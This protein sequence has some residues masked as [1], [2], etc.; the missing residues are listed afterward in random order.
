M[1]SRPPERSGSESA[2]G[3]HLVRSLGLTQATALVAGTIIGASIF[4]QAS[5]VTT[6]VPR[7]PVILFAWAVSGV[8]SLFGALV[9]AE[10]ASAFPRSGGIYVYLREEFG[11]LPRFLWGWSMFWIMHSGIIAVM[12]VVFARYVGYFAPLD[13]RGVRLVAVAAIPVISAI[14]YF[15]VKLGSTVQTLFTA[16]KIIAIMLLVS[17][18]FVVG[19]HL[20]AH[21]AYGASGAA[22]ARTPAPITTTGFLLSLIAGLF[23]FGGWHL[24]TYTAEETVRPERTIPLALMIGIAIV[25]VCYVA[26]NTLYF[27]VLPLDRVAASTRVAADA[28]VVLVGASAGGVIS[29]LVIFSTFG[30]MSGS[31]LGAPRVY[32]AMARDGL[33]F[34]W[35]S[36]VHPRYRTPHRAIMLQAVWASALVWTGT[37]RQLFTRVISIQWAF[38]AVLALGVFVLRR[39][40]DYRPAY[41]TWGYPVV[42]A[43]FVAASLAIVFTRFRSEPFDSLLGLAL[44]GLG[45]PVYYAW[46][47]FARVEARRMIQPS[48]ES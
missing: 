32:F 14:N 29:G 24:V 47:R 13:D 25:T 11:P 2:N 31:I 9:C 17:V 16:G 12:A 43:I 7:I 33:L 46:C 8:L 28:A 44:V 35:V 42:P 48:P 10:L 38:F 30:A 36:E 3:Q 18:G 41:R 4:V 19:S 37:Y 26:L 39:R 5:E 23:T 27:Y 21:F 34:R 6:L 40:A 1:L 15:G 20:S 22:V 45:I